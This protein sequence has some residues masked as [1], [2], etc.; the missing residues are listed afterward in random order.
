MVHDFQLIYLNTGVTLSELFFPLSF[1]QS[2]GNEMNWM[3]S[4]FLYGAGNLWGIRVSCFRK[5]QHCLL[6]FWDKQGLTDF[7]PSLKYFPNG[8]LNHSLKFKRIIMEPTNLSLSANMYTTSN[9]SV[10]VKNSSQESLEQWMVNT[11]V[12]SSQKLAN[13]KTNSEMKVLIN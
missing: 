11:Q 9:S 12:T 6:H 8:N 10:K 7:E 1:N 13:K 3:E 5:L 2:K 4:F